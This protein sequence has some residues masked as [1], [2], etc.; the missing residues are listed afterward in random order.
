MSLSRMMLEMSMDEVAYDDRGPISIQG[1]GLAWWSAMPGA[2][3]T[4][5]DQAKMLGLKL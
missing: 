2:Q 3:N 1:I 5:K 4:D